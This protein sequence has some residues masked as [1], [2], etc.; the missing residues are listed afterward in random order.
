MAMRVNQQIEDENYN[1]VIE[2]ASERNS[3]KS[4]ETLSDF[5]SLFA[6]NI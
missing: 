6:N 1:D 5:Q 3:L 4:M 2:L